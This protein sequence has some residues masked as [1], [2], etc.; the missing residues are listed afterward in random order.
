MPADQRPLQPWQQRVD[1]LKA[2][3][4]QV[5]PMR[6]GSLVQHFRRC[7]KPTCHCA[8]PGDPGHGPQWLLT[9]SVA[10]KTVSRAIP[11]DAVKRTHR[12]IQEYRRFKALSRE[13]VEAGVRVCDALLHDG[14][15]APE[16]AAEKKGSKRRSKRKSQ[17]KSK[18]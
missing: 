18:R 12:Q 16:G 9:R 8:K 4:A 17:G 1:E 7:G 13:L 3:I 10:G 14:A 5:G 6:P 15:A 11:K 2:L